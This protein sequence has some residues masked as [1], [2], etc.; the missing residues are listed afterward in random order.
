MDLCK[1]YICQVVIIP[2][3]LI[4]KFQPLDITVNKPAKSFIAN[5]DNA[6]FADEVTKHLVKGIKSDDVKASLA[7]PEIK[8]LHTQW[9][10]EVHEYHCKQP[11]IVLE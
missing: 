8:L 10:V 6:W 5:K 1:E 11:E 7:H 9:I 3:N 4:N 2:H